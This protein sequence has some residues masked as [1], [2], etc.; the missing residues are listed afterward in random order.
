MKARSDSKAEQVEKEEAKDCAKASAE[1]TE[2]ENVK[3]ACVDTGDWQEARKAR[4]EAAKAR[5]AEMA[6]KAAE[7]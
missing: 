6:A 1:A 4:L 5:Q 7:R 3:A 2:E